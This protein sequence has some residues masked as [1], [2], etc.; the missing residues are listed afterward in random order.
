M[1]VHSVSGLFVC[2]QSWRR[3]ISKSPLHCKRCKHF[4]HTFTGA[5]YLRASHTG[6]PT[7]V[8]SVLPPCSS[9]CASTVD[10]TTLQTVVVA[11]SG[12]K[13]R[14]LLQSER[15]R[16]DG[17]STRLPAPEAA[18]PEPSPELERLGSG[19]NHVAQGALVTKGL[20]TPSTP[21]SSDPYRLTER[22]ANVRPLVLKCRCSNPDN[23]I[24]RTLIPF[25]RPTQFPSRGYP[26]S[27]RT[28][29]P[30]HLY[31]CLAVVSQRPPRSQQRKLVPELS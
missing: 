1:K 22:A 2:V 16:K 25:S 23:P 10:V 9:L 26:V 8:G 24:P 6:T 17:C 27:S 20:A 15:G 19:W 29:R 11:V 5:T 28:F 14:Q 18:P 31:S 3:K 4:G 30:R 21:I 13:Q 7:D 12:R